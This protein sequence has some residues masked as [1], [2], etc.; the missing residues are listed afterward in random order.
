MRTPMKVATRATP[1]G[2]MFEPAKPAAATT[3]A[4]DLLA[5]LEVSLPTAKKPAVKKVSV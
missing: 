3:P 1:D 5:Q 4:G 2:T